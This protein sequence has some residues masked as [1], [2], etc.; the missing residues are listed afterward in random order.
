MEP[1]VRPEVSDLQVTIDTLKTAV[2]DAQ[3]TS[4]ELRLELEDQRREFAE[5]QMARAQLQGMLRETERRL[6]DAKQII[7]L[8]REEL[9]SARVERE[10]AAQNNRH[11]PTRLRPMP[12]ATPFQG[13][14][15]ATA[16]EGMISETST[17]HPAAEVVPIPADSDGPIPVP[18]PA[19][20]LEPSGEV[21]P[22]NQPEPE[23]TVQASARTIIVNPG[24]TLWRLSRRHKVD[25]ELLRTLNG[26]K[27]YRIIAGHTLRLPESRGGAQ[28][29]QH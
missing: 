17:G 7:D 28:T 24:D 26:L 12:R 22:E 23:Q 2:R 18:G 6:A 25:M 11:L 13:T 10:R 4:D 29:A 5:V 19:A 3:R 27:D 8:Q 15:P 20:E 9:A 16:P 21:L 1:N 14:L